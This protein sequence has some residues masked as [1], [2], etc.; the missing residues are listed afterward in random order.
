MLNDSSEYQAFLNSLEGVLES[1]LNGDS[2]MLLGNF[3][4]YVGNDSDSRRGVIGRNSLSGLN[5]SGVLFFDFCACNS[6]PMTNT[7]FK[8]KCVHK[9]TWHQDT[10]V[11]RSMIDFIVVSSDLQPYVLDIRVK[12][13]A[14]LSTDH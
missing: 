1:A 3:N 7:M 12:R 9:C 14:E 6:L 4:A 2:F 10:L 11:C 8:H 13:G 5:Q